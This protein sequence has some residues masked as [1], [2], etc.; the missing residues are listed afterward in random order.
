MYG[1]IFN[2]VLTFAILM[3]SLQYNTVID[4]RQILN[5]YHGMI[6]SIYVPPFYD[7]MYNKSAH[8]K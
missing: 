2:M 1:N 7:N 6:K 5:F 4:V 3:I 8:S